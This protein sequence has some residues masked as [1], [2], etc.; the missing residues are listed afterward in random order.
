[1]PQ[2]R[3][4]HLTLFVCAAWACLTA[5]QLCGADTIIPLD[6]AR[7]VNGFVIVPQCGGKV[8]ESDTAKGFDPFESQ[9]QAALACDAAFAIASAQ[10][11]SAIEAAS[12]TALG[13]VESLAGAEVPNVIHAIAGTTFE[14]T[15]ELIAPCEFALGGVM[16]AGASDDPIFAGAVAQLRFTGPDEAVILDLRVEPGRGGKAESLEIDDDG[17]L[18]PGIYTLWASALTVIDNDV[19]PDLFA[20]ASFDFSFELLSDCPADLDANGEVGTGDLILLL[21]AWGTDPGGPPDFDGDG[22]VGTS[23]LIELLGNWGPCP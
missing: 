19:P 9:V 15:F 17:V 22:N 18:G 7:S 14:V 21:G 12:V 1:M 13:L 16:T 8:S 11:H 2:N 4:K 3:S 20:E 5:T 6:Q 23:D 10:Q